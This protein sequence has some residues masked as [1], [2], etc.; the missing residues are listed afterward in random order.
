MPAIAAILYEAGFII[1][2]VFLYLMGS[3]MGAALVGLGL[4]I[5]SYVGLA[6]IANTLIENI[7]AAFSV[8]ATAE[9]NG[10]PIGYLAYTMFRLC[11]GFD[12]IL[13]IVAAYT[14]K[15]SLLGLRVF[16]RR[17]N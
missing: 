8:G 15:Y 1:A 5:S 10:I 3:R 6:F 4:G 9:A 17:L 2:R 13:M 11:G 14:T 12:A 7:N 16:L